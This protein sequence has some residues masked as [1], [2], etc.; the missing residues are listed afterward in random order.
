[1]G[2]LDRVVLVL[3]RELGDAIVIDDNI[4]ATVAVIGREFV[5]L[6]MSTV[7]GRTLETISLSKNRSTYIAR[8]VYE[9]FIKHLEQKVRLGFENPED[10]HI[11]RFE[12]W[13]EG[14]RF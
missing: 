3:S 13:N 4:V 1:M 14:P 9:I 6:T 11:A 10:L 7:S 2:R 12:F 8:G 5:D